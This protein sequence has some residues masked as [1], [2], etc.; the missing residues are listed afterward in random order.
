MWDFIRQVTVG[1]IIELFSLANPF[2]VYSLLGAA[3]TAFLWY[4]LTRRRTFRRRVRAF[5]RVAVSRRFWGHRS[6][7]L[8][9]KLF[10]VSNFV[11][12]VGIVSVFAISYAASA[13]TGSL[14]GHLIAP[15]PPAAEAS[16]AITLA[17]AVVYWVMFDLGYWFAHWLMHRIPV[18]WEFHKV[19]HSAEVLSPLT[20]WRQH[21]IELFLFPLC[22]GT[23]IGVLYGAA[24]H[25]FGVQRQG[26][27]LFW[28][29][30]LLLAYSMTLL[31]LRHSQVWI[32]VR[33]WLGYVIQ[34]PAHHQIH[35][36][37]DPRHFNKNLG[38]GLSIWDWAFRTLYIPEQREALQ[39]GLGEESHEHDGVV[40]V[41]TLPFI[42]AGR[43]IRKDLGAA[44]DATAAQQPAE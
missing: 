26:L 25:L 23:T 34:S 19:H 8:D 22:T 38:Y 32:P 29:N 2:S 43:L 9:L 13:A 21:P 5:A 40:S 44:P 14:L 17:M 39:F 24:E 12:A 20:E 7:L 27:S 41:L 31:H 18:L 6:T 33:G 3:L 10:F 4:V 37:T 28:I 11:N 36:S 1:P 15:A 35:H 42:K 30:M 16:L